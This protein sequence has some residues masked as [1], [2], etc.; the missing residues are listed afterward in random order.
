[1]I[2]C[3]VRWL[4]GQRQLLLFL[5]PHLGTLRYC[6]PLK[7]LRTSAHSSRTQYFLLENYWAWLKLLV[8]SDVEKQPWEFINL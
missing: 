3:S 1:M 8:S 7:L 5:C 6:R 2:M 4:K